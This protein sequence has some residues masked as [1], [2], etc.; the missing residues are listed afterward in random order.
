MIDCWRW[1]LLASFVFLSLVLVGLVFACTEMIRELHRVAFG[2]NAGMNFEWVG[3]ALGITFGPMIG[4]GLVKC[5][6]LPREFS[7]TG[8]LGRL[9]VQFHDATQEACTEGETLPVECSD[10]DRKLI[11]RFR[12]NSSFIERVNRINRFVFVIHAVAY[13]ALM[14]AAVALFHG[15]GA[16]GRGQGQFLNFAL[17]G[18]AAGIVLGAALCYL[19]F[20]FLGGLFF[21]IFGIT[22][23]ERLLVRYYDWLYG[24]TDAPAINTD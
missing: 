1:Q 18:F 8:R 23:S 13:I 2:Q 19:M 11:E 24:M 4:F 10:N 16:L 9:L 14:I 12:R 20:K 6:M 17:L 15:L 3:F 22:R 7:D 5:V 21:A